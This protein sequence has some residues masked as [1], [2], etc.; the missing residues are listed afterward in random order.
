VLGPLPQLGYDPTMTMLHRSAT[1]ELEARWRVEGPDGQ[2]FIIFDTISLNR[3][4]VL[5]GRATR[6]WKAW[7]DD[8]SIPEENR[9]VR[10]V[11]LC[12]AM[13]PTK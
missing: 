5:V 13:S 12:F 11:R 9:Q 10:A 4:K 1:K 2:R 8:E 7:Q 6:M 3:A